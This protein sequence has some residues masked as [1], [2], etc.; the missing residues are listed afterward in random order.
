MEQGRER[1]RHRSGERLPMEDDR[2]YS[3]AQIAEGKRTPTEKGCPTGH[4]I[5][6]RNAAGSQALH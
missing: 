5:R 6:S 3:G 4:V 1:H 2:T